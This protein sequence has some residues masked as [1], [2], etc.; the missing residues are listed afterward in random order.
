ML[1]RRNGWSVLDVARELRHSRY[2]YYL[3][4]KRGCASYGKSIKRDVL[5]SEFEALLRAVQP[6]PGLFKIA[7]KMFE[8][9]WNHRLAMS[10][11]GCGT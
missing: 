4:H 6:T 3:C 1:S 5:E 10:R 11:L 8:E 9:L 7:Q 2:P